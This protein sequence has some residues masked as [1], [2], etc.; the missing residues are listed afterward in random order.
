MNRYRYSRANPI[1]HL[2]VKI[3]SL[4]ASVTRTESQPRSFST[5][6]YVLHAIVMNQEFDKLAK[7]SILFMLLPCFVLII[8]KIDEMIVVW[9]SRKVIFYLTLYFAVYTV[10]D[11]FIG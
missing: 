7:I 11:L 5:S 10:K 9:Y 3:E 6:C 2:K 8:V 1:R 4:S